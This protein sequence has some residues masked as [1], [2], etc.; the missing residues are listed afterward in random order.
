[1]KIALITYQDN[2]KYH[3]IDVANEDDLLITFLQEKG[4]H[5]NK[6]IWN[7]PEVVWESYDLLILKSTWDYFDHIAD[8]QNWLNKIEDKNIKVLNP[9]KTVKW[10]TDKHYLID[11]A[12]AGLNVTPSKFIN[13]H[14]HLDLQDFFNEFKTDQLIIK[15]VISGGSKNT[16]KVSAE[17]FEESTKK[18]Q[19]LIQFEDFI[20][21]PFL[22]E[23]ELEGEYSFLLV[24]PY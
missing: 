22:K 10:N 12:S 5:V 8:F 19:E 23:I 3:A 4:L 20:V 18:L 15:P 2:G 7:D 11:I 1:M 6:E 24:T 17:N 16:F 14:S 9:I 13:N 21:Q